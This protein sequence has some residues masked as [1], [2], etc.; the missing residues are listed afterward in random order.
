MRSKIASAPAIATESEALAATADQTLKG[1][2]VEINEPALEHVIFVRPVQ[3]Y[4]LS[5]IWG[6]LSADIS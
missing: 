1:I 4:S 3:A 2:V 5:D 6:K